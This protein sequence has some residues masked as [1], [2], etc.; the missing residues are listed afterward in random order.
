MLVCLLILLF[1][2]IFY[3]GILLLFLV[4]VL[5]IELLVCWIIWF[6]EG[7]IYCDLV[8]WVD[9]LLSIRLIIKNIVVKIVVIWVR[10]LFELLVLNI[11]FDVL[12]LNEVFMFVFLF[13][14]IN[15]RLMIVIVVNR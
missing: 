6:C 13:C 11:V 14:W 8:L 2:Y 10:K 9:I 12:V 5:F 7:L 4:G 1:W 3:W 15:I